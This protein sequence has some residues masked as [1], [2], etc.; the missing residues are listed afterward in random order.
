MSAPTMRDHYA[1][2]Y[3]QFRWHI[4]EQ[5]NAA[6]VDAGGARIADVNASGVTIRDAGNETVVFSNNLKLIIRF[7]LD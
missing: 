2:L 1:A 4:D 3:Q 5:F 6:Q 7:S